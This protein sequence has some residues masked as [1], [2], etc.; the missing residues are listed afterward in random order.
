MLVADDRSPDG[1]VAAAMAI[2]DPRLQVVV[3]PENLGL[4]ASVLNALAKVETPYVALLNSDDLFHPKRLAECLAVLESDANASLVATGFTV[5]DRNSAVLTQETS[6]AADIGPLAH[7]WLRWFEGISRDEL[8][9]PD[10]W[11]SFDVLLRHNVLT[12][13]SNM[14]F[15][16][17]WLRAH[18]PEASRLK[19]C[20]D[21]QLFLQAAMEGSLRMVAEPLLAYRL[22][23]SNTVWF[24][25]GGRADY[26]MEVN[27]VVDRVLG[28]WLEKAVARDGAGPAVER[29]AQILEQDVRQHGESD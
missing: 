5:V 14:V 4:G 21:W 20:V 6:C 24:R 19:Y 1:T 15:R 22:H 29:L 27:R 7:Q 26:V 28:Q 23:D 11:T 17:D 9:K 18:M 2:E 13:S 25:E 3:N 12:T 8:K 10:D 16:T